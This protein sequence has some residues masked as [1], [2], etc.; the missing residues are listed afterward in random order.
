MEINIGLATLG[1]ID[2]LARLRW[3]L[4]TEIEEA[5][6]PY[7]TYLERFREFG[8]AAL[9]GEHWCAWVAEDMGGLIGAIWRQVVTRVPAPDR[10]EPR[11]IGYITSTYVEPRYR[12][13]GLGARLLDRAVAA[14]R[15][16]GL[17]MLI[18]WPSDR[19]YPFYERAGFLRPP[20]PLVLEL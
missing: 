10:P 19:S 20:A 18:V 11:S 6:E 16:E 5:R 13:E 1:D 14:S 9:S 7:E 15:E 12:D 8:T 4:M 17:S 2:E 3:E